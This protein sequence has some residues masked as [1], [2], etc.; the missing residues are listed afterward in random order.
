M[1]WV[2]DR[3]EEN[4]VVLENTQTL[5]IKK[6]AGT[7]LPAGAR[8]GDAFILNPDGSFTYDASETAARSERIKNKFARLQ[9]RPKK[10]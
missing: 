9:N 7:E 4:R 1:H 8:E 5:E 10:S 6:R 2:I 3:F